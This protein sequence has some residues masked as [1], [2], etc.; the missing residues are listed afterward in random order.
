MQT[1]KRARCDAACER[2]PPVKRLKIGGFY[3]PTGGAEFDGE[4]TPQVDEFQLA[5][6]SLVSFG[7]VT[8]MGQAEL[9]DRSPEVVS[10]PTFEEMAL[11]RQQRSDNVPDE[12]RGSY[13]KVDVATFFQSK[14]ADAHAAARDAGAR[15]AMDEPAM[16]ENNKEHPTVVHVLSAGTVAELSAK[17]SL[18]TGG[19][20]KTRAVNDVIIE[21]FD[22]DFGEYVLLTKCPWSRSLD[23]NSKIRLSALGS[24][25][26]KQLSCLAT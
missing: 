20:A 24:P 15:R 4:C 16:M 11:L 5:K 13:R 10:P 6:R 8:V 2:Q 1:P 25:G 23:D 26:A 22:E 9:W 21:V 3:S 7:A 14:R 12:N 17:L 18:V 19:E